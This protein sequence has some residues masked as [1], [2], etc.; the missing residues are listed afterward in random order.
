MKSIGTQTRTFL[1][2]FLRH[3]HA[4][5][6]LWLQGHNEENAK[7]KSKLLWNMNW[8]IV[9]LQKKFTIQALQIDMSKFSTQNKRVILHLLQ[10]LLHNFRNYYSLI[11]RW[12]NF[13]TN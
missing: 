7:I 4:N 9:Q 3:D 13:D 12:E 8:A 5:E 11:N 2:F 10:N 6:I 1:K